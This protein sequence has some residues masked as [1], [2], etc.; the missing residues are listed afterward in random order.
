MHQQTFV[1][2][3]IPD[4][5]V[6]D[7]LL[8]AA[9]IRIFGGAQAN[10]PIWVFLPD[11]LGHLS[12]QEKKRFIALDATIIPCEVDDEEILK[13]PFA[14]KVKIASL[15]EKMSLGKTEFLIWLDSDTLVLNEP[16]EFTLAPE[17]ILGY[18]PVHHRL[19]GPAWNEV[20]DPFWELIYQECGVSVENNFPMF[21]H[22]GE[23]IRPYF[24]AGTF[25]IR[26]EKGLLTE[27]WQIFQKL[28]SVPSFTSFYEKDSRYAIFMHQAVFTGVL[29]KMLQE[30]D[31]Q[32]LSGRINYPLHLHHE[33]PPKL[34]PRTINELTTIRHE[35]I[36][37][38]LAWQ[39]SLPIEEPL[40][41]WLKNQLA[42]RQS[43]PNHEN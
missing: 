27:W 25:V 17:K 2:L 6:S 13:F 36:F 9:S 12:T 32:E 28:Y 16:C 15:A 11:G 10:A 37:D 7:V 21:T 43:E 19:I 1:T 38:H 8:L 23:K 39:E 31:L 24:N 5:T 22:T 41:G 14:L 42:L 18:R 26:P 29:L 4:K 3:A 33:I 35:D 34:R 20:I 40:L 30:K